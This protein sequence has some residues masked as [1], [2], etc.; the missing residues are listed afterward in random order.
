MIDISKACPRCGGPRHRKGPLW[1]CDK[2]GRISLAAAPVL[3]LVLFLALPLQAAEKFTY[4]SVARDSV[5]LKW[6][7]NTEPD[8]AGYVVH[9]SGPGGDGWLPIT[10]DTSACFRVPITYFYEQTKFWLTAVD[11]A[12]NVSAPSDTISTI[13]C[14]EPRL[15][16]DMNGDGRVNLIDKALFLVCSGSSRGGMRYSDKADVNGDGKVNLLDKALVQKNSG[17]KR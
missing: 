15:I 10:G 14:K 4:F 12:N 17:A 6:S 8:L 7:P 5:W 1:V 9:F 3:L 11:L 13:L 16:G 2:C